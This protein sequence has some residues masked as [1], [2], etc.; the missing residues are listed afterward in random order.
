MKCAIMKSDDVATL[1]EFLQGLANDDNEAQAMLELLP[2]IEF[3]GEDLASLI[4]PRR[5]R[6][7]RVHALDAI[8]DLDRCLAEVL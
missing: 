5:T 4:N 7:P 8:A 1:A 3:D 2:R 6:N